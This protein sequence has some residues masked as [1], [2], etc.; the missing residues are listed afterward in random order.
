MATKNSKGEAPETTVDDVIDSIT[1]PAYVEEA[2]TEPKIAIEKETPSVAT[3]DPEP[4]KPSKSKGGFCVYLGPSIQGVITNGTVYSADRK[5]T[6]A[7]IESI[8]K[9][10]PLVADL[11]VPGDVLP[12]SRVKIKTPGNLLYVN[13]SKLAGKLKMRTGD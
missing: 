7:E 1:E 5:T 12:E 8:L 2:S 6:I 4:R 9:D 10:Y 3:L 11:I 13:Y